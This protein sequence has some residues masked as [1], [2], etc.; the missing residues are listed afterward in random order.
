MATSPSFPLATS[1]IVCVVGLSL[2]IV[3]AVGLG[4]IS[5]ALAI[6]WPHILIEATEKGMTTKVAGLEP[7]LSLVIA[8]AAVILALTAAVFSNLLTVLDG[9]S[10]GNPFTVGNSLRLRRIG[11]IILGIQATGFVTGL[12]GHAIAN[13]TDIGSGFEFS[14]TGLLAALLAFVLAEVFEQA[15][16]LRDDL[17]GTV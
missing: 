14:F 10:H 15:R 6:G 8:G 11:W 5:A 9:V 13:R 12:A 7:W 2:C 16:R 4:L 3:V 1:R 17:E